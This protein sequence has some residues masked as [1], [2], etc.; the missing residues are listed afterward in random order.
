MRIVDVCFLSDGE[1]RTLVEGEIEA[2]L[3]EDDFETSFNPTPVTV[4][5]VILPSPSPPPSE[6]V[7]GDQEISNASSREWQLYSMI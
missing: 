5:E 2:S 3:S 1:S 7:G 6:G 4:V